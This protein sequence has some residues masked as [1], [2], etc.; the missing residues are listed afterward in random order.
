MCISISEWVGKHWL[1]IPTRIIRG[2]FVDGSLSRRKRQR[3]VGR[4]FFIFFRGISLDGWLF[5]LCQCNDAMTLNGQGLGH[6]SCL[7]FGAPIGQNGNRCCRKENARRQPDNTYHNHLILEVDS[8]L[9]SFASIDRQ[10]EIQQ[11]SMHDGCTVDSDDGHHEHG[12]RLH[13]SVF[14][15]CTQTQCDTKFDWILR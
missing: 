11:V 14:S 3:M 12:L 8:A 9:T 5:I 6:T 15:D 2:K 10:L 7:C 13:G 4:L 1:C